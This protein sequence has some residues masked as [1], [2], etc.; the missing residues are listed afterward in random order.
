MHLTSRQVEALLQ[1]CSSEE[2]HIWRMFLASWEVVVCTHQTLPITQLTER[3][4]GKVWRHLYPFGYLV[5]WQCFNVCLITSWCHRKLRKE[6]ERKRQKER[7]KIVSRW[8][9]RLSVADQNCSQNKREFVLISFTHKILMRY[10]LIE[11]KDENA[12]ASKSKPEGFNS[13]LSRVVFRI[14]ISRFVCLFVRRPLLGRRK[15]ESNRLIII[16]ISWKNC[17]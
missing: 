7:E 17:S 13:Q 15:I 4:T 2:W 9:R 3:P 8:F 11:A 1:M 16:D 10:F 6:R 5:G 12:L 14:L